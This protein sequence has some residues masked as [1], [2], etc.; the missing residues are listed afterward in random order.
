MPQFTIYSPVQ[1]TEIYNKKTENVY[2]QKT[3]RIIPGEF[4][5]LVFIKRCP[6]TDTSRT[7]S[8]VARV[9][10]KPSVRACDC[11]LQSGGERDSFLASESEGS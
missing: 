1:Y 9:T 3:L 4:L 11:D 6:P 10:R 8:C 5:G 7:A 2:A